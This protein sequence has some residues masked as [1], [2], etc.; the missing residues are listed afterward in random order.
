LLTIVGDPATY[1]VG[2]AIGLSFV[3]YLRKVSLAGLVSI[4]VILPML[5]F[6][7]REV[8]NVSRPLP[9]NPKPHPIER[10][11]FVIL[12]TLDLVVMVLLFL[13]GE[14]LPHRIVPPAVAI[15][16][17]TLGLLI[18]HTSRIE[19]VDDVINS[20]DW[21]TLLFLGAIFFLVRGLIKTGV[22]QG[23]SLDMHRWLGGDLMMASLALLVGVGVLSG[24]VA[25]IPVVAACLTMVTGYLVTSEAVPEVALS[26]EF[27]DW[28]AATLPVFTGLILG[29]TLG[30][31]ATLIGA[32]ANIVSAGICS[33]N[34]G[35]ITFFRFMRFGLPITLAQLMAAVVYVC[36]LGW[37]TR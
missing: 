9:E 18:V 19:P 16:S 30:G 28:P 22:L 37:A 11:G 32:S 34:G 23:L 13:F 8:W 6:V 35:K 24:F 2:S 7:F 12:A 14:S 20:V 17:A 33:S 4:L 36:V 27:K 26:T 31:N 3:E 25:N 21:K 15:I 10:P 1:L 5:P 29:G